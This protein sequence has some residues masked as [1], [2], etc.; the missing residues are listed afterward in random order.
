[1]T[2]AD[3]RTP[4]GVSWTLMAVLMLAVFTV[5]VGY[6]VVLP[7]L[8]DLIERLLGAG[9]LRARVS[10]HTGLLTGVYAL[11]LFLFAPA[12]G[13]LSDRRGRRRVLLVGLFGFGVTM[14]VSS[15]AE[16]LAAVYAERFLSGV[17]ASAVTPVAAAVI[18]DFAPT[19]QRRIRRLTLI[20]M[21]G[22]AGFLLGPMF[23]VILTRLSAA[24]SF[25]FLPISPVTIPLATAALLA[26]VVGF[27]V[28]FTVRSRKHDA[29][30]ADGTVLV[31]RDG[32]HV[33]RLLALTFIV[34]A[35]IGVFEVGLVL[36]GKQELGLSPTQ[37]ALMFGEC[38]LV[39]FLMQA[40]VFSP[41]VKPEF[42]R[43]LIGP[44]LS[45]L[46]GG[47]F[48][49]PRA[50]S[51][52]L[53]LLVIGSVAG[54]GGIL[55]PILT[56]WIS[57]KAGSSQGWELGK[58]T[59]AA[60]L[61]ATVGSSAGGFLFDFAAWPGAAFVL[62]AGLTVVGAVLSVGLPRRLVTANSATT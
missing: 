49:V 37:I 20:S 8:P 35:A 26:F 60:S 10:R 3:S 30:T 23:G 53:M 58:Q 42:T 48:L 50:S 25:L 18:G 15:L 5:S 32:A 16:S 34:S 44:A 17:F 24:H 51:F 57:A 40:I 52:V 9:V 62:T 46:A 43:W 27:A 31:R 61:G 14:A 13:K 39:M 55:S 54:S 21:A 28:A 7:S 1:M 4:A 47:L 59:A 2:S 36:R 11:A 29:A 41:L 19:E 56:Y 33:P 6:G 12:W 45:I 38:S 22:I